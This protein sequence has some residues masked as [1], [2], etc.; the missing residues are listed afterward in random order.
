MNLKKSLNQKGQ[1]MTEYIILVALIAVAALGIVSI[2]GHTITSKLSQITTALQGRSS[3]SI[4]V[5]SVEEKH[6][7]QR[8]M[9]DFFKSQGRDE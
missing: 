9:N 2:L 4:E 7:R 8:S 6:W 1:G 3:N 5:K